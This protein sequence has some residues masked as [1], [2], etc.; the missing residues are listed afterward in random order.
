LQ[1]TAVVGATATAAAALSAVGVLGLAWPARAAA[2]NVGG[3]IR[4]GDE[5]IMAPKEHGTSSKPV[6]SDL[7]YGVSVK[8]ADKICN[9]NRHFAEMGG[10]FQSTTFEQQVLEAKGPLTFYDSVTG[11]PLFVAPI[12]RSPEQFIQE[13]K[14]HGT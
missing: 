7:L 11:K 14:I 5:S 2:D 8:L 6:Q 10:Y 12:N 1:K 13:S 3:T 4:Y 9:F